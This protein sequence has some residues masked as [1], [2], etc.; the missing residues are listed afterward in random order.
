MTSPRQ[1]IDAM[2]YLIAGQTDSLRVDLTEEEKINKA[3]TLSR[4]AVIQTNLSR[5]AEMIGKLNA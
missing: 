4:I 3:W 2:G 1:D 5:L